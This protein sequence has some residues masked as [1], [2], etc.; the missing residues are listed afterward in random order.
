[1]AGAA[2]SARNVLSQACSNVRG[3]ERNLPREA[4]ARRAKKPPRG[5]RGRENSLEPS[6]RDDWLCAMP[7]SSSTPSP[8]ARFPAEVREAHRRFL[9]DHQPADLQ[10]I[11]DAALRDFLPKGRNVAKDEPVPSELRLVDGLGFD[12]LAVAE[13]VFFFEDLFQVTI[14]TQELATVQTVGDLRSFVERKLAGHASS[15]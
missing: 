3:I 1:M 13:L 7:S 10:V 12:S 11:V 15:S 14:E 2:G 9:V 5:A 8:L 6:R 4:V